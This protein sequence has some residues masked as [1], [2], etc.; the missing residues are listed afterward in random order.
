MPVIS[1]IDRA[2]EERLGKR[3]IGTTGFR[4]RACFTK[5]RW[6]A[7]YSRFE[8]LLDFKFFSEK[9][10]RNIA[11]KVSASA[12]CVLTAKPIKADETVEVMKKARRHPFP[13]LCENLI[14]GERGDQI[15]QARSFRRARAG[16]TQM[17]IL[18][19]APIHM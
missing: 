2:R 13:H 6:R 1:Q 9:L 8:D 3:A 16:G 17:S 4:N 7:L 15:R 14:A 11:E 12:A 5:I 10:R 19:T 18:I